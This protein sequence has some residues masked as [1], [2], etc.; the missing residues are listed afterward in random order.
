M[1]KVI[2]YGTYDLF[3]Y[4][5]QRLL[6]R[7]KA[8]GDYLIVGVTA[9]GFDL[10]RGKI[11]NQQSLMERIESV[12]ATGLADEIIVEEYEGQ[13]IDDIQRYSVDIFTVGSDWEGKFDYLNEYCKVV[14]LPRTQGVSS[15]ELRA[16][17]RELKLGLVGESAHLVKF[18]RECSYV[19]GINVGGVCVSD[20]TTVEKDLGTIP[21]VTSDFESLLNH[22]DAVYLLSHPTKHYSQAKLALE[23]KKHVLCEAPV[24]LKVSEAEELYKLADEQ[25]C[26]LMPGIKTAFST[27]YYRLVLLV[28]SGRIGKPIS[29]DS[30][31]TSMRFFNP[32]DEKALE[33]DWNSICSWGPVALLPVF[34]ILGTKYSHSEIITS[35]ANK[36][37]MYDRFT[38][39]N[40]IYDD[41]VATVKVAKGIKAEGE[42]VIS[43]TKGYIYIPAPWWKTDYFEIRYENPGD[44]KKFFYQLEGEG[45]RYEL[46]NFLKSI[47]NKSVISYVPKDVS[48]AIISIIEKFYKHEVILIG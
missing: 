5:H 24:A 20:Q 37:K 2:T 16:E 18:C 22:V 7:A 6:E 21:F 34:Q 26:V 32:N 48:M 36:A 44:N 39:L 25:G 47:T 29:I 28:K 43:G 3:H 15:S 38:K 23:N 42:L 4:G 10:T 41:A 14:Y 1:I 11:N 35:F 17:K 27:A 33:T 9:D 12:R 30:T 8:L 46:V 40:F 13:K 31:C 45:I 19:N